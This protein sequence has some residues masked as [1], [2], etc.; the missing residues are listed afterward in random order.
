[1]KSQNSKSK[2]A[3][4]EALSC[5]MKELLKPAIEAQ[6][7]SPPFLKSRIIARLS[8]PSRSTFGRWSWVATATV[9]MALVWILTNLNFSPT[10]VKVEPKPYVIH[11][12]PQQLKA[13]NIDQAEVFLPDGVKFVSKRH[14]EVTLLR[15]LSVS[16]ANIENSITNIPFV[17]EAERPGRKEIQINFFR[18]GQ[19]VE[20]KI[21]N[22]EFHKN[23]AEI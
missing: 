11:I 18:Q 19:I 22:I 10:N 23:T 7:Q 14:A 13:K 20:K 12:D 2:D 8:P 21:V 5:R 1:M 9:A 6:F 16:L 3:E 17:V 4:N 15:S